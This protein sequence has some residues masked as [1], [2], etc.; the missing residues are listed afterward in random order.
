[1]SKLHK[2]IKT[3]KPD[4]KIIFLTIKNRSGFRIRIREYERNGSRTILEDYDYKNKDHE[5]AR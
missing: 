5:Q 3:M 2:H 1:M 4:R